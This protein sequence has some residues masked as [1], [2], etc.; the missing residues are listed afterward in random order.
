MVTFTQETMTSGSHNGTSFP[1]PVSQGSSW[2]RLPFAEPEIHRVDPEPGSTSKALIGI[3]SQTAGSTC[4]CWVNPV[5]FTFREGGT[6]GIAIVSS[7][8]ITKT[9]ATSLPGRSSHSSTTLYIS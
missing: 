8:L 9:G 3:F 7:P 5:T 6:K 2:M 4:E 1:H